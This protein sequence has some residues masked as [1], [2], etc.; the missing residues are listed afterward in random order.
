MLFHDAV[1][2]HPGFLTKCYIS[3]TRANQIFPSD[4]YDTVPWKLFYIAFQQATHEEH[5]P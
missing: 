1:E 5:I 4:I 2:A 3:P